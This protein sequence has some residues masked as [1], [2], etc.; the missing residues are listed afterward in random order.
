[1]AATDL[2]AL[3]REAVAL[4]GGKGG[5]SKELAQGSGPEVARLGESLALAGSVSRP[6]RPG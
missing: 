3:L 4:L 2:G 6:P 5:G 1:M